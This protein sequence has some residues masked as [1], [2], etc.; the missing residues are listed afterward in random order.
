VQ[1]K[2]NGDGDGSCTAAC[3]PTLADDDRD[4]FQVSTPIVDQSPPHSREASSAPP[5]VTQTPAGVQT[6]N[7]KKRRRDDGAEDESS[8]PSKRSTRSEHSTTRKSTQ[9]KRCHPPASPIPCDSTRDDRDASPPERVTRAKGLSKATGQSPAVEA[10]VLPK[11][12]VLEEKIPK[13][14]QRLNRLLA[15]DEKDSNKISKRIRYI[16]EI[17]SEK[18]LGPKYQFLLRLMSALEYVVSDEL[19]IEHKGC[20]KRRKTPI[21]VTDWVDRARKRHLQPKT[22]PEHIREFATNYLAWW[23]FVMPDWRITD[24]NGVP[25]R[26]SVGGQD[27]NHLHKFGINGITNIVHYLGWWGETCNDPSVAAT[28]GELWEAMVEDLIFSFTEVANEVL[29]DGEYGEYA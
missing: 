15:K 23:K 10:F 28:H 4:G 24:E 1:T 5:D 21:E 27:W 18:G 12:N 9:K 20:F 2:G 3:S 19:T 17:F 11:K 25:V 6:G 14:S 8:S 13:L 22:R 16:Y 29:C 26:I 7:Q